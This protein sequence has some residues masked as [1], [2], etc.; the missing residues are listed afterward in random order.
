MVDFITT[1]EFTT[2]NQEVG[3]AGSRMVPWKDRKPSKPDRIFAT[4]GRGI[5]GAVTEYRYGLQAKIGLEMDCGLGVKQSWL[6]P[7]RSADST[8]FELLLSM[9]DQTAVIH[10]T[11][12]L[13]LEDESDPG[14]LQYDHTS[15]TLAAAATKDMVI[16]VTEAFIVLIGDTY[17]YVFLT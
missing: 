2:W 8:G 15:R 12:D 10:L 13:S 17:W 3:V 7:S 4:S 9:P 14:T 5:K 1:D 16:Q 6:L 11:E